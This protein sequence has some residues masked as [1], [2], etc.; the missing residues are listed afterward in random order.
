MARKIN[1]MPKGYHT[2]T[3]VLVVK[4]ADTAI[5]YY[6]SVFGAKELTRIL[7]SDGTTILRAELKIGNSIIHLNDEIPALGILSPVSLGGTATAVQLYLSNIDKVW[8]RA[9]ETEV[10]VI[11]PLEDT[12]WGERTGK[13]IDPFGH[14]WVLSRQTELLS[15]KEI[16]KRAEALF[17]VKEL[18]ETKSENKRAEVV[19]AID[20][21]AAISTEVDTPVSATTH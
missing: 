1:A 18:D 14:V 4:N 8:Q 5:E 19:P 17:G 9:V 11:L 12:Y 3:P 16:A 7:S 20:L 15:R 13:I 21:T 6:K 2:A 10:S